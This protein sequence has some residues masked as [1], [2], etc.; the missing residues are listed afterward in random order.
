MIGII[1]FAKPGLTTGLVFRA[2]GRIVSINPISSD[3]ILHRDFDSRCSV[4][5]ISGREPQ[6]ELISGKPLVVKLTLTLTE[7]NIVPYKELHF[8]TVSS[9]KFFYFKSFSIT[10]SF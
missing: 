4:E 1:C 10:K 5:K 8:K 9:T 6:D 3:R 7:I 2:K